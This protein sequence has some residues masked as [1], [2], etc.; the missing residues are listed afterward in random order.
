MKDLAG[1]N[2]NL[3]AEEKASMTPMA[4]AT[5]A[6]QLEVMKDLT[7]RNAN[8]DAEGRYSMTPMALAA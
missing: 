5:Q 2:A 8:L 4:L 7:G 3:D 1:R 6:G